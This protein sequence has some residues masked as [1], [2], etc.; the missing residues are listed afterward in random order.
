[1]HGSPT[2]QQAFDT[3]A[4]RR[5]LDVSARTFGSLPSRPTP[6]FVAPPFLPSGFSTDVKLHSNTCVAGGLE[7]TLADPQRWSGRA[8][9]GQAR[10]FGSPSPVSPRVAPR[11]PSGYT[12]KSDAMFEGDIVPPQP[13]PTASASGFGA[14]MNKLV[15]SGYSLNRKQPFLAENWREHD[16]GASRFAID[17]AQP[18]VVNSGIVSLTRNSAYT[19]SLESVTSAPIAPTPSTALHPTQARLHSLGMHFDADPHAHKRRS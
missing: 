7:Y 5:H 4:T 19:R 18:P 15:M 16:M 12:R 13:V 14:T 6:T 9:I 11:S 2:F 3:T 1:M 17:F 8:G 10:A